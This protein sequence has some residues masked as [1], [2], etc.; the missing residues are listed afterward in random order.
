[1]NRSTRWIAKSLVRGATD[2]ACSALL[3]P[4]IM[5]Y[6][7]GD[8]LEVGSAALNKFGTE[9]EIKL[10]TIGRKYESGKEY[11]ETM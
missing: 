1:M 11:L 2:A 8:L 9:V 4:A 3:A 6:F 10:E 7:A 5:C